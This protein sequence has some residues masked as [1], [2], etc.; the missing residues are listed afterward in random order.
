VGAAFSAVLAWA[1]GLRGTGLARRG[2]DACENVA[3]LVGSYFSIPGCA[4]LKRF[5][6]SAA[7]LCPRQ[8]SKKIQTHVGA[9]AMLPPRWSHVIV[10]LVFAKRKIRGAATRVQSWFET[11]MSTG[12]TFSNTWRR[13]GNSGAETSSSFGEVQFGPMPFHVRTGARS[14]PRGPFETFLIVAPALRLR[15]SLRRP[16]NVE[17]GVDYANRTLWCRLCWGGADRRH[18]Q[19]RRIGETREIAGGFLWA[20]S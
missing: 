5:A 17:H 10:Q 13:N 19:I 18:L 12:R 15:T 9:F 16:N 1:P 7:S 20:C 3:K 2:G 6:T 14:V 11:P 4:F 8:A